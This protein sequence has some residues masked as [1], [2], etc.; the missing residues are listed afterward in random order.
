[1]PQMKRR[2]R[3]KRKKK[4]NYKINNGMKQMKSLFTIPLS[5]KK[6]KERQLRGKQIIEI[7]ETNF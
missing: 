2:K 4:G 7:L 5:S 6:D 3:K 1:M